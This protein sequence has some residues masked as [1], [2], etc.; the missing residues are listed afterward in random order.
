M[1]QIYPLLVLGTSSYLV[2]HIG[3]IVYHIVHSVPRPGCLLRYGKG[4]AE[5]LAI[6]LTAHSAPAGPGPGRLVSKKRRSIR[7][8][9]AL[10]ACFSTCFS[11]LQ[12]TRLERT[13]DSQTRGRGLAD[14]R[15]RG[16][17]GAAEGPPRPKKR[18]GGCDT[19]LRPWKGQVP[20]RRGDRRG[21]K[22][23]KIRLVGAWPRSV[24]HRAIEFRRPNDD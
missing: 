12:R 20:A 7:Q 17:G 1:A 21:K 3:H 22:S 10:F 5:T 15:L 24:E 23:Q 14:S 2:Y 18:L 13:E 9:S 8:L 4:C 16:R 11:R 19:R 6:A